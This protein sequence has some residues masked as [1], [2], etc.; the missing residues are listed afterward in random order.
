MIYQDFHLDFRNNFEIRMLLNQHLVPMEVRM[1]FDIQASNPMLSEIKQ[2]NMQAYVVASHAGAIISEHYR[3][4][5]S[6]EEIG[7]LAMIFALAMDRSETQRKVSILIVC[8]AGKA[9]SRLLANRYQKEFSQY[10]DHIYVCDLTQ[11]NSFDYEK[12]DYILT[13]VNVAVYVPKPI[14]EVGYFFSESSRD[15]VRDLLEKGESAFLRKYFRRSA[16]YTDIEADTRE[17]IIREMCSRISMET[18][19]PEGF[20]DA[21]LK[22]EA[23]APTDFGNYVALPH[24]YRTVTEKTIVAVAILRKPVFWAKNEVQIIILA[25]TGMEEDPHAE[26]FYRVTTQLIVNCPDI[27]KLTENPSYEE[28][29]KVISGF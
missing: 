25:S 9:S 6:E 7:F 19:L 10:L 8:A 29:M 24:P 23:L 20:M 28:F 1:L 21:V 22:R 5:V 26:E 12:V 11:L 2:Y 17:D 13:T 27:L 4:P 15:A 18:E 3:K 16:F 14:L